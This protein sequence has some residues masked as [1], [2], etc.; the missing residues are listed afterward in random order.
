MIDLTET[1]QYYSYI[2]EE[3]LE[4]KKDILF[5]TL[6]V[7]C[8]TSVC[9]AFVITLPFICYGL[10]TRM[11]TRKPCNNQWSRFDIAWLHGINIT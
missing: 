7:F 1:E 3:S 5:S 8:Y 6:S 2:Y 4:T 11:S 10:Y 9:V